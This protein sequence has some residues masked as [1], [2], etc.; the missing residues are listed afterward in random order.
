MSSILVVFSKNIQR[1]L[2][3][4]IQVSINDFKNVIIEAVK[5]NPG[6]NLLVA[7]PEFTENEQVKDLLTL[8]E[9]QNNI[10]FINEFFEEFAD[11]YPFSGEYEH[12]NTE[13]QN[14]A[15]RQ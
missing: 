14:Q 13:Q 1:N 8:S 3:V 6:L 12:D 2:K 7:M 11:Q 5:S 10:V 9:N 15:I 4:I